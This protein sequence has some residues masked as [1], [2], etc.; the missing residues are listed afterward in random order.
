MLLAP[1]LLAA[2]AA[3]APTLGVPAGTKIV[4]IKI[5]R[6][7]VFDLDNPE[8][9]SWPYRA[10]NALHIIS[11]ESF[12]RS[13]L[14]FNVG[15]PVEPS[16]LAESAR[17]LRAT[18]FL[19]PVTISAHKV[20]GG[21]EVVVETRDE[22]TLE[23]DLNFG[24][25][26]SRTKTGLAVTDKNFLGWGKGVVVDWRNDQERTSVT[27]GYKDPLFLGSR[28]RLNADHVEASDGNADDL[29]LQYPFFAYSTPFA[30]GIEWKRDNLTE[31]LYNRGK[32]TVSGDSSHTYFRLWGGY[33][34]PGQGPAVN[35]L[36]A[37]FFIER[38]S[39]ANWGYRG[40]GPYPEPRSRD[41]TG[42]QIGW[43]HQVDRWE[44]IR[45]FRS[46]RRQEDVPLGP[47]WTILAGI[48]LPSFGG[49]RERLQLDADYTVGT[50]TGDQYSWL[51]AN[52]SGRVDKAAVQNGVTHL[53]LGTV[54][55][56]DRG[57]RARVV[58]DVG[59]NLDRDQQLT[60][61]ADVG[62]R[63]WDPDY[64]DGTS[65]A[66]ANL[67]WR[68]R[69]TG[70][71]LHLA[72]LG[73]EVFADAGQTWGARIGEGTRGVRADAGLGMVMEITRAATLHVVRFEVAWP[74]TGGGPLFLVTGQALF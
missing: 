54:R 42:P 23:V 13:L 26:G 72:I 34:L 61:G 1:L 50:L 43:D 20:Q 47:N 60:L 33:R 21:A 63:G 69:L 57:W 73:G 18:G 53:E 67:E 41:L 17:L 74:D 55:F 5:V 6:H 58:T 44:V 65:R 37:G 32:K 35:R 59:T 27:L 29:T 14:L 7:D 62:L 12:I 19:N 28:W 52:F 9:S 66:V 11:R 3:G 40:D 4:A 30:G 36:L 64:F 24:V 51:N 38:A 2:A 46:W 71:V 49:D 45:G 22:W 8:T 68:Q 16:V 39:Y 56:G 31:W 10:A 48:S 70:E 15:D 25:M